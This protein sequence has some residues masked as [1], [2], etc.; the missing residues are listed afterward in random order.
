MKKFASSKTINIVFSLLLAILLA[1]YVLSLK[2]FNGNQS[3]S[4]SLVPQKKE[5]ITVPL[6]LQCNED[7]YVV[8]SAPSSVSVSLE[9]SSALVTAAKNGNT[10]V[11][12]ADM[13]GL[14][15][16]QHSVNVEV[17]GINKSL[18]ATASPQ[19]VSVTLAEKNSAKK[20]VK[21]QY[22]S[23]K[24]A[25]GYHVT[26]TSVDPKSVAVTGPKANV[27]AVD[28]IGADVTLDKNTKSSVNQSAKLTAYDKNGEPVQV[29]LSQSKAQVKLTVASSTNS[30]KV[31]LKAQASSGS[32]DNYNV[33]FDPSSVTIEGSNDTL[34]NIDSL[35]VPLDLSGIK[36]QTTK[37]VTLD[38]PN[39]VDRLSDQT[40]KV[41][42]SPKS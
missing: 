17:L 22:D 24:L 4:Y 10:L 6:K 33:S 11:A 12:T 39:G 16:G 42:I 29:T 8:V 36:D 25:S 41:T 35:V 13:R 18:T 3:N 30:K 31:N 9:G 26:D 23:D 27:D 38:K 28:Y 32:L 19:T 34:D 5:S 1:A 7:D 14:G 2:N 15:A 21:V 40:V 37:T 20:D